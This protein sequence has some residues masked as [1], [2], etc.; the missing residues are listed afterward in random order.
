[1]LLRHVSSRWLSLKKVLVRILDQWDNLQNYFLKFLPKE[2][3]FAREIANTDRYQEIKRVLEDKNSQPYISYAVFV[4]ELLDEFLVKFQSSDPLIHRLY[5]GFGRLLFDIMNNF[6]KKKYLFDGE[7][8]LEAKT[9]GQ[10][11]IRDPSKT[12]SCHEIYT[13][14]KTRRLL[15][16]LEQDGNADVI[17]T[18]FKL[19]YMEMIDYLQKRLPHDSIFLRD[20]QCI[21]PLNKAQPKSLPAIGRMAITMSRILQNTSAC[22]SKS[23]DDFA[24]LIKRQFSHYQTE[25]ITYDP[26][27]Q[28]DRFW[29]SVKRKYDCGAENRKGKHCTT[30]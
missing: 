5:D 7:E 29:S 1:M 9:L 23:P 20:A 14:S 30:W 28:I 21:H 10:I 26:E 13:G 18:E 16:Q 22:T 12:K 15:A 8:K 27:I 4:A 11:D 6:V 2:K 25:D 3:N 17:K 19:C 24:D